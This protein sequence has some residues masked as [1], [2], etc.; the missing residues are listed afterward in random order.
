MKSYCLKQR[1]VT[2][3]S[4]PS[5]YKK[6]E[7]NRWLFFCRCAECGIIKYRFVKKDQVN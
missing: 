6:T 2:E 5:G 3:C 7:N 1:K 4:E